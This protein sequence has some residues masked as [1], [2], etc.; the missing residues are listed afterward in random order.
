MST[1]KVATAESSVATQ[2]TSK[3]RRVGPVGTAGS[4]IV[5]PPSDLEVDHLGH[6]ECADAHPNEAAQTRDHQPLIG[7]EARHVSGVDEPHQAEDDERKRADDPGGSLGFRAHC[8]D[9]ELHLGPLAK[10]VGEV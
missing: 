3:P 7:E 6:D 9:L 8:T 4:M 1:A 10:H 2:I 5:S